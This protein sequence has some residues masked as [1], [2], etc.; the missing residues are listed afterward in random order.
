MTSIAVLRNSPCFKTPHCPLRLC[1]WFPIR[2]VE[3]QN[4]ISAIFQILQVR[5]NVRILRFYNIF[6]ICEFLFVDYHKMYDVSK[7][8]ILLMKIMKN[9]AF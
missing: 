1:E 5:K 6:Q 4:G 3:I 2:R 7:F 9:R 8:Q